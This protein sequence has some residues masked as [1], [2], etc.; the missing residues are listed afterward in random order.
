MLKN[1]KKLFRFKTFMFYISWILWRGD[2]S[3][4]RMLLS[5][6]STYIHETPSSSFDSWTRVWLGNSLGPVSSLALEQ[7][8]AIMSSLIWDAFK[9]WWSSPEGYGRT[10][11]WLLVWS[12][13]ISLLWFLYKD[14]VL[15]VIKREFSLIRLC[16]NNLFS[17]SVP[18]KNGIR[19]LN[20]YITYFFQSK[21]SWISISFLSSLSIPPENSSTP[22]LR[23]KK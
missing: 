20:D 15:P 12:G 3:D 18:S 22:L 6:R 23:E 8:S 14:I 13:P 19:R 21:D 16:K 5:E 4:C 9:F 1:P 17:K 2:L 11:V 7:K 10:S